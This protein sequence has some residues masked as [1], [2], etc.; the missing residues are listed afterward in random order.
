MQ[1]LTN[2]SK[3]QIIFLIE[4]KKQELGTYEAVANFCKV[5]PAV[6]T[7]LR[8][9]TYAATG[10][11]MWLSVGTSLRWNPKQATGSGWVIVPTKDYKSILNLAHNVKRQSLFVPISDL[12]G[13]GKSTCLQAVAKELASQNT[14]YIRCKDWGKREFLQNLCTCLGI[15]AYRGFKTPNELLD[16]VIAFFQERVLYNPLLIIDE[17]DKLKSSAKL[18][19]IPL[20][21]ECEDALACIIA[22]TENLEKEIKRGVRC[23]SKGYDEIDSRFGRNYMKLLGCTVGEAKE[24]CQAN[25]VEDDKVIEQIIKE[26]KPIRKLIKIK[27]ADHA[28]QVITDLRRLKRLVQKQQLK[29][30]NY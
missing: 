7:K 2:E 10:D 8:T 18:T 5:S 6:I 21:N 16:V 24:I 13:L 25:G 27:Q 9:N 17:A 20:Y 15:D 1:K 29:Q 4:N 12:A 14:F 28:V 3:Q 23:Q 26:C 22:G 11:D 30:S 19:L